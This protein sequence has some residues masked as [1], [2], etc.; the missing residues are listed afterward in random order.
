MLLILFA[1]GFMR[2]VDH[3]AL[4][5]Y[6]TS[7]VHFLLIPIL[8]WTAYLF[9]TSDFNAQ[10]LK[11]PENTFTAHFVFLPAAQQWTAAVQVAAIQL[12]PNLLY[13]LFLII[14]SIRNET[15]SS[16]V[17][18]GFVLLVHLMIAATLLRTR[19]MRPDFE[20][21][22]GIITQ[23]VS[24]NLIRPFHVF[25][26]EWAVRRQPLQIIGLKIIGLALIWTTLYLY[27]TDTYDLRLAGVGA[28]FAFSLNIAFVF[29]AH[30]FISRE[31]PL[32]RQMPFSLL[33]RWFR[34]LTVVAIFTAPELAVLI[35]NI[36][37][38]FN[39]LHSVLLYGFGVSMNILVF[40]FLYARN[41]IP[42][43]LM[44]GIYAFLILTFVLVLG[45]VPFGILTVGNGILSFLLMGRF[46]YRHEPEYES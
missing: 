1:G 13:G 10:L 2:S 36:P 31:F 26:I 27:E 19:L 35:R 44:P 20:Q 41:N 14:V 24:K 4:A 3:I 28:T 32:F 29:V 40:T 6:L 17:V 34:I 39:P 37:G 30:E 7:S 8:I 15:S 5:S 23:W 45:K 9:Y 21:R 11:L 16:A 18:V 25:C 33:Q 22:G 43:K 12:L 46:Y 38:P 42:E